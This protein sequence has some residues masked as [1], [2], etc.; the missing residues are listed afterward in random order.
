MRT[1]NTLLNTIVGVT[2]LF[3]TTLL[4]FVLRTVFIKMLGETYLGVNGLLTNI[5]SMLSLAELGIGS[6]IGFSLYKPL[7]ENN[8]EKI[9]SLMKYYKKTYYIIGLVV[10]IFGLVLMPFLGFF[11]HDYE[12]IQNL[13][14]IYLLYLI[15]TS[16]T[17][18]FSYKRTLVASD[19]KTYKLSIYDTIFRIVIVVLQIAYIVIFK[20]FIG[21]LIINFIITFL[22][23]LKINSVINKEYPYLKEN[24]IKELTK[25][26]KNKIYIN[27]KG[28]IFHKVGNYLV[29]GTDNII[30]SKFLGLAIVGIYSNYLLIINTVNNFL[31]SIV[32]SA[33]ASFG[34]LIA[35]SDKNKV[36]DTFKIYN[37]I[38]FWIYGFSAIAFYF[39]LNPF[40]DL[41]LG[42]KFLFG[43]LIVFIVVMNFYFN[44]ML[45]VIDNI[46]SSAGI[47]HQD[48]FVP[49]LQSIVNLFFSIYLVV[50]L[51]LV[52][53]FIG[54]SISI[55][56]IFIFKPYFVYKYAFKRNPLSYF[57]TFFKYLI[58]VFAEG[59]IILG[60]FKL[61]TKYISIKVLLFIIKMLIVTIIPNIINYLLFRK[62]YEFKEIIIR[63]KNTRLKKKQA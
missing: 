30:I 59:L 10:F 47:Y 42:E 28:L 29:N 46:K 52:G 41:W 23:N 35:S 63:L 33:T 26:K 49:I 34:N 3:I 6:A 38:G 31:I 21:Y 1:K 55:I 50:K 12:N 40:I 15:N 45:G 11:M 8:K 36:Y 20:D 2:T 17:Y 25:K 4:S 7:N 43:T 56:I 19:Q 57:I 60:L 51:G 16:Y 61:L 62:T 53:V 13:N 37:F 39:L 48:R 9:K 44:S 32:G 24:N 54:T 5:L 18:L 22:Q 27:I 58:V 14:L